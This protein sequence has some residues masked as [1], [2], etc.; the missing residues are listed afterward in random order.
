MTKI[1]FDLE[2]TC[3]AG[4]LARRQEVIELGAYKL[5]L[6]GEVLDKFHKYV[7]PILHPELSYYCRELT[8]LRQEWISSAERFDDVMSDFFNWIGERRDFLLLSWGSRDKK[9]IM[10][11]MKMHDLDT[12]GIED[13]FV[14]LKKLYSS[15]RRNK[16]AVSFLEALEEQGLEFGGEHHRAASD[17]A[18]LVTLYLQL[19]NQWPE[20]S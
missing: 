15:L 6:F 10:D 20:H 5:N 12:A 16:R 3:W 8:G 14:D 18:N 2:A 13:K 11:N 1:I 9:L 19:R 4:N 17:A 7:C